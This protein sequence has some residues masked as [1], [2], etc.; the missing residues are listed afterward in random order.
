MGSIKTTTFQKFSI[1]YNAM[2][3]KHFLEASSNS[4][5]KQS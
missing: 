2:S 1:H 5:L 4:E 3:Q